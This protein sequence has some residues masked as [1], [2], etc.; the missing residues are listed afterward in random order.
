MNCDDAKNILLLYRPGTTDVAD[1]QI[2]AALALVEHD[3]ELARWF[4]AHCA[5]QEALRARLRQ[6]PVPDGLKEQIISEQTAQTE[7][8]LPRDD[9]KNILLLCRPG[10]TDVADPQIA[11]ALALVEQDADL[12]RWF[13]AH[14]ARQEMLRARLRQIPVPDGLKEQ[15]ISEQAALAKTSVRRNTMVA[16]LAV[17]A[18]GVSVLVSARYWPSFAGNPATKNTLANYQNRMI[19]AATG[20]YAMSYATNDLT[21]IRAYLARNQAPADYSLPAP[22]EKADA[23]GCAIEDWRGTKVSM[24][25]FRTGKPLPPGQPGDLWLFVVN[26]ASV[27]GAPDTAPPQFIQIDRITTAV[28]AQGDKLYLLGTEG[29]KQ[30]IQKFL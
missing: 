29:D 9:A 13:G 19:Y 28:W 18:I 23:T 22:L 12:K 21:Q 1:P 7:I 20:G 24:I 3:P 15:I 27:K 4:G 5:R 14:C 25:C 2:A 17:V 11:A 8:S 30:A 6:I 26:R 10:V 16:A